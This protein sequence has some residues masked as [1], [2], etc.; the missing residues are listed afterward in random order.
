MLRRYLKKMMHAYRAE[1]GDRENQCQKFVMADE[2]YAHNVQQRV[3]RMLRASI[4]DLKH[5]AKYSRLY[6]VFV[7][8]KFFIKEK[9][10]LDKYLNECN[11][12]Q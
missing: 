4:S 2:F 12:S 6:T 9:K 10:L 8:W 1:S 3:F 11:Y 5:K 7:A